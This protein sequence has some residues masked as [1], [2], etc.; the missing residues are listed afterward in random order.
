MAQRVSQLVT[1]IFFLALFS[2]EVWAQNPVRINW[3]AVT[4]AQSGIFMA[5]QEKLFKKYGLDVEL[6]HIPSSS[7]GIQAILAGEIAFSFMD[8]SNAAQANLK[9]ANLALRCW[10]DKPTSFLAHGETRY[11]ADRRFEGQKNRYHTGRIVHSYLSAL[12]SWIRGPA[13]RR[14]S[15]AAIA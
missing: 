11:Q 12:C 4:G 13:A 6:I 14:L 7:R 10:G 1:G 9:G 2:G 8:G 5:A 15:T 3:T